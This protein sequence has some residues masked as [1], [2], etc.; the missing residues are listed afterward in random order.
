MLGRANHHHVGNIVSN[1]RLHFPC[2]RQSLFGGNSIFCPAS[3]NF[4][5][6][7]GCVALVSMLFL[8]YMELA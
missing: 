5:W 7:M 6:V 8:S 2:P 3:D 4:I 1:L